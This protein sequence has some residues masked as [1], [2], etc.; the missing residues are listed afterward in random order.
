LAGFEAFKRIASISLSAG[1]VNFVCMVIGCRL[2][3][4]QG[5]VWGLV[6]AAA[7]I[8]VLNWWAIAAE[9]R[10]H[11]VPIRWAGWIDELPVLWR[12]SLPTVGAGLL[13]MPVYW[14][15][16]AA[17]VQSHGFA[18]QAEYYVG[19]QWRGWANLL[20]GMLIG[21][22]LPVLSSVPPDQSA[23]R[24]RVFRHS[25]LL[26]VAVTA[27]I[28][29]PMGILAAWILRLYGRDF[30]YGATVVRLLLAT[31]LVDAVNNVLLSTLSAVGQAWRRLAANLVWACVTL[32]GI[33]FLVPKYGALGLAAGILAGQV[34]HLAVQLPMALHALRCTTRLDIEPEV[35]EPL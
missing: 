13:V 14:V 32:L 3:G 21:A 20:P 11:G 31:S 9:A 25:I 28:A 2:L 1:L 16:Q 33:W 5:A 4:V 18:A 7:T 24:L 23:R 35:G 17:V 22:V 8:C 27:M 19:A 12:F 6:A 29:I 34:V 26:S 15:G 30:V 10:R